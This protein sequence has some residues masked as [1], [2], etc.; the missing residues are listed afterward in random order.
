VATPLSKNLTQESEK[1]KNNFFQPKT[2]K[3]RE[4]GE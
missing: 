3:N 1:K 4:V 2:Q